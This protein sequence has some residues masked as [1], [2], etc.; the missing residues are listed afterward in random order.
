MALIKSTDIGAGKG[1]N[2]AMPAMVFREPVEAAPSAASRKLGVVSQQKRVRTFGRQQKAAERVARTTTELA[3]GIAAAGSAVEELR[4]AMEQIA[5]GAEEASSGAEESM[6]TVTLVAGNLGKARENAS[7][8]LG[9]TEGLQTL[10]A[11]VRGHI[12]A[13]LTSIGHA[14]E[15]QFASVAMVAELEKQAANIGE[16]VKAVRADRRSDQSSSAECGDRGGA[17]GGAWQGLRRGG[18]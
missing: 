4:R 15:R 11:G 12:A 6:R 10:I 7:G 14:A 8:A 16:I 13:S 5:T 17:C 1:A 18:R 2:G 9:K 3:N